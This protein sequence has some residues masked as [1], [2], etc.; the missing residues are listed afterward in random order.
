MKV[1]F[2]KE[3]P[4]EVNNMQANNINPTPLK[5]WMNLSWGP[6]HT[7]SSQSNYLQPFD[8]IPSERQAQRYMND[9]LEYK[10]K[11]I[12]ITWVPAPQSKITRVLLK[13]DTDPNKGWTD[14]DPQLWVFRFPETHQQAPDDDQPFDTA[15]SLGVNY[16]YNL[17][18]TV[19][20]T[21]S[22]YD[23]VQNPGV[24]IHK[25]SLSHKIEIAFKAKQRTIKWDVQER[26]PI[27]EGQP[28]CYFIARSK[29]TRSRWT[30]WVEPDGVST[31]IPNI[32]TISG[33]LLHGTT[34]LT[35]LWT[36]YI[37]V[38]RNDLSF[39]DEDGW[40]D[41]AELANK[42]V[43]GRFIITSEWHMRKPRPM[44]ASVYSR[45]TT[46]GVIDSIA[47]DTTD[48]PVESTV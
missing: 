26:R 33:A 3:V 12:K 32:T 40:F 47:T 27:I 14:Y 1:I 8:L 11:W 5:H 44:F 31:L 41:T 45:L 35:P 23:T 39:K 30:P 18:T 36:P 17:T 42:G 13:S 24:K 16:Q 15:F 4:C 48:V 46:D 20:G 2:K 25:K 43:H 29:W 9:Y 37:G 19:A 10:I 21:M 22:L 7:A 28:G 38:R 34:L 6:N